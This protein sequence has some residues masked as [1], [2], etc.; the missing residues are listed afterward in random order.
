M[1]MLFI[2]LLFALAL[3]H[4]EMAVTQE[5]TEY[6]KKH[7]SWEVAD[8][9][10][11]VFRGWT[12]G[13]LQSFLGR[14]STP[15]AELP[16]ADVETIAVPKSMPSSV[17]WNGTCLHA[18]HNQGNCGSCWAFSAASVVSDRCCITLKDQ[19]WLSPQELVSCDKS[20]ENDGCDG[21]FEYDALNYVAKH[22]L[23]R[24]ACFP[25]KAKDMACPTKCVDGSDWAKAHVCKCKAKVMCRGVN[26][27]KACMQ[28]GP[29][30][31]GL[32]VY[33]DFLY[34]KGGIYHWDHKSAVAGEHAIR[35]YGYSD[36]PE[37]H[38][39]CAN[40]WGTSWGEKGFFRIG[41]GESRIDT[42]PASYCD[43]YQ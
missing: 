35:C 20:G 33:K 6:L 40:S 22:G 10:D 42:E 19:G 25:Y 3:C 13:D 4:D 39:M 7:V 8:Y 12:M 41:K 31:A 17:S 14:K 15:Y 34:Y 24:E 43:P 18:I 37:A 1:K 23:V 5:Y 9:E 16:E 32:H 30:T 29:V 11:N 38:W 21:G 2:A 36:Q 27:M 28:S 26:A